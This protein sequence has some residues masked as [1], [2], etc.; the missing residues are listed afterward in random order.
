VQ[1]VQKFN[2]LCAQLHNMQYQVSPLPVDTITVTRAFW[3][4]PQNSSRRA[5][6]NLPKPANSASGLR[7]FHDSVTTSEGLYGT[8]NKKI[9]ISKEE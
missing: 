6:P 4:N 2:Y 8:S 5:L 3:G 9:K 1:C 7:Y